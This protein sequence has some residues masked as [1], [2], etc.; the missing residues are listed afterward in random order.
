MTRTTTSNE[1]AKASTRRT[2][3]PQE[4][5]A[6]L[7][8]MAGFAM[9]NGQG[10][11]PSPALDGLRRFSEFNLEMARFM[12]ERTRKNM[13]TMAAFAAC[14]SPQEMMTV[15]RDATL[16]AVEDYMTETGR[17]IDAPRDTHN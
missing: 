17:L 15:W 2:R 11:P 13:G 14:R 6:M 4:E 5:N 8:P 3:R 7:W 12:A 16:E 1:A 9:T 10:L